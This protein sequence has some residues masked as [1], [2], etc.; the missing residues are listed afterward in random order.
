MAETDYD[1]DTLEY[2][3]AYRDELAGNGALIIVGQAI[4]LIERLTAENA[5]L[6]AEVER[7]QP[8]PMTLEEMADLFNEHKIDLSTDWEARL[9]GLRSKALGRLCDRWHA[10]AIAEKLLRDGGEGGA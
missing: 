8:K 3:K 6:A 5:R 4:T 10:E 1:A 7:L 9:Y 2:M